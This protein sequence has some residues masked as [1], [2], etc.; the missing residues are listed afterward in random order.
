MTAYSSLK[1]LQLETVLKNLQNNE[2]RMC[3]DSLEQRW[4]SRVA[5]G[6]TSLK[7]ATDFEKK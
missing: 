4:N 6:G 3:F 7:E 1:R 5:A 2:F